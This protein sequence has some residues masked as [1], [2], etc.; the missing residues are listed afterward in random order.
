[1]LKWRGR[2]RFRVYNQMKP[3]KYG[4]KSYILADPKTG[5]CWNLKPYCGQSSTVSDTVKGLLGRLAGHGHVLYMDNYYNSVALSEDLFSNEETHVCGML[6]SHIGEPAEV[7][8]AK[9]PKGEALSV[10]KDNMMVLAWQDK[11]L[12]KMVTTCHSDGFQPV[13]VR[14]KGNAERVSTKPSE[15]LYPWYLL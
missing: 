2:L 7:R 14:Q 12:V 9:L 15:H 1:M 10:H 8:D 6:R 3:I 11:K 13:K 4:I 5:Y